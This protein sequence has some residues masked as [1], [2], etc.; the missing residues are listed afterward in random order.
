MLDWAQDILAVWFRERACPHPLGLYDITAP[1][2]YYGS[3][4]TV[5]VGRRSM[6]PARSMHR[7]G[8]GIAQQTSRAANALLYAAS[9]DCKQGKQRRWVSVRSS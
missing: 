1:S 6:V 9:A 2:D 8:C 3:S 7:Q 5:E 4:G